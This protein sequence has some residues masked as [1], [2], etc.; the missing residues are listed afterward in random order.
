MSYP[1]TLAIQYLVHCVTESTLPGVNFSAW[2][3]P[4]LELWDTTGKAG[5]TITTALNYRGEPQESHDAQALTRL[6]NQ[7]FKVVKENMISQVLVET[8]SITSFIC[9]TLRSWRWWAAAETD[10][11]HQSKPRPS[12]LFLVSCYWAAVRPWLS[13][14]NNERPAW[15]RSMA[16]WAGCP[17]WPSTSPTI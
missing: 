11:H 2:I 17:P 15:R 8:W 16:L 10:V 4:S 6:Q 5:H 13:A 12:F 7:D 9:L 1:H 3:L 14:G